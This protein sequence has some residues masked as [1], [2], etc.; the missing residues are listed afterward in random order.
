[1]KKKIIIV[2]LILLIGL[3]GSY[4][5]YNHFFDK[6]NNEP[7]EE[8]KTMKDITPLMYEVTKEGSNSKIYLFGSIHFAEISKLEF[9]KY[10]LDAYNNSNSVGSRFVFFN[11]YRNP[12]TALF[13]FE[14]RS[15]NV[16]FTTGN[17]KAW[18]F[19][20]FAI[21]EYIVY[22]AGRFD[23]IN[24]FLSSCRGTDQINRIGINNAET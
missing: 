6:N 9:P 1:M 23:C 19:K 21:Y 12:F 22:T 4:F 16:W 3:L 13:Y 8:E 17:I 10:V 18:E 5:V 11:L 14:L 24:L 20:S 15:C 7:K 2:I